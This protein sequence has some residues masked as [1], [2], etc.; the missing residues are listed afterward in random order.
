[1]ADFEHFGGGY[2][3]RMLA[4]GGGVVTDIFRF[5]TPIIPRPKNK[6]IKLNIVP[7]A[8]FLLHS[9]TLAL[10]HNPKALSNIFYITLYFLAQVLHFL[11]CSLFDT[12]IPLLFVTFIFTT[13]T[14][15]T[16]LQNA[17]SRSPFI[18]HC[19]Q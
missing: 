13:N 4:S 12:L 9:S 7:M 6:K 10:V 16:Q 1:M 14:A 3:A 5:P 17:G 11:M 19:L 18:R 8:F 2:T 15:A